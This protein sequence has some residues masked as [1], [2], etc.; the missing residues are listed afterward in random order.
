MLHDTFFIVPSCGG[1]ADCKCTGD[2]HYTSY[3]YR[4][5]PPGMECSGSTQ[6]KVRRSSLPEYSAP[7]KNP[8]AKNC[9]G[10]TSTSEA[11]R[12]SQ[13]SASQ[14]VAMGVT[15][16][17]KPDCSQPGGCVTK[18][19]LSG[20]QYEYSYERGLGGKPNEGPPHF[21]TVYP[22]YNVMCRVRVFSTNSIFTFKVKPLIS[23]ATKHDLLV[24]A[25]GGK[26]MCDCA[27]ILNCACVQSF[28]SD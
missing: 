3:I 14:A 20:D 18:G 5:C 23:T 11:I 19:A 21:C 27:I 15:L 4:Q 6:I 12:Q 17:A 8:L 26:I 13:L 22:C 28:S 10:G 9:C 1:G 25:L 24:V 2:S 7:M 16:Y